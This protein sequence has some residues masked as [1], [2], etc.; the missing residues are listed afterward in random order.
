MK[1]LLTFDEI[2]NHIKDSSILRKFRKD[3]LFV[4][5]EYKWIHIGGIRIKL[6]L[7]L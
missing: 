3:H 2:V 7:E 4:T 1:I 6:K 5:D